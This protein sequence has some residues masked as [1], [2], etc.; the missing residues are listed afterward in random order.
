M[1]HRLR[2][3]Q[4]EELSDNGVS[5][6]SL[7]LRAD[8]VLRGLKI[9][10][11]VGSALAVINHGDRLLNGDVDAVVA[12]KILLTYFVPYMVSTWSSVQAVRKQTDSAP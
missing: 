3:L 2:A 10:L 12:G 8:I 7:A 5:W 4:G 1:P 11:I 6:L 9:A